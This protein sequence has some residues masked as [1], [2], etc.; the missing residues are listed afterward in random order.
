MNGNPYME[1][2]LVAN[3]ND[4]QDQRVVTAEEGLALATECGLK[5]VEINAKDY[6]KVEQAFK[7]VGEA[8]LGKIEN[9]V[10]P[11]NQGIGVKTGDQQVNNKVLKSFK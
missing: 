9:G 1:I 10:L 2:V 7:M 8:I 4:L 6:G 3:K 11:I 5:F